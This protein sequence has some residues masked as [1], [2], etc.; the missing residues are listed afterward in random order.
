MTYTAPDQ[1]VAQAI[2]AGLRLDRASWE[3]GRAD[4]ATGARWAPPAGSDTLAYASGY[5][6][7]GARMRRG[8][9]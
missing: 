1:A 6:E 3:R 4:G 8:A 5:V 9:R 2:A 7:G